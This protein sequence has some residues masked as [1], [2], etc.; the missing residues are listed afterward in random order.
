MARIQNIDK[1]RGVAC[2]LVVLYHCYALT[3]LLPF[4]IPVL[5]DGI[6]MGG[7]VG[8]T[9]FFLLSGYG[10]YFSINRLE[11]KNQLNY[12]TFLKARIKRI[13]PQYYFNIAIMLLF[14]SS[15]VYLAKEHFLTILSHLLFFHSW[16]FDW[17]GAINGVLWTMSVIFQFYLIAIPLYKL[18]KK[19]GNVWIV[20]V[21]S[22]VF[23]ILMKWL[24]LNYIWVED[25][26][27][28]GA[29]AYFIPGRQI[30]TSLDNFVCG[31]CVASINVRRKEITGITK[32]QRFGIGLNIIIFA[33]LCVCA[34]KYGISGRNIWCYSWYSLLAVNLALFMCCISCPSK[35]GL[36]SR[37]LLFISKH[38]YGIYLWHL[39][40]I[41]NVVNNSQ[42]I[43]KLI[44]KQNGIMLYIVLLILC[45]PIGIVID[46]FFDDKTVVKKA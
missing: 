21:I 19:I 1:F 24:M 9:M 32:I 43:R 28:Y 4:G 18:M 10:I 13:V 11:N 16:S 29:Y 45:V 33:V 30:V 8:V 27:I 20:A 5:R 25:E 15:V 17:H 34:V 2:L 36:I 7:T 31:M 6:K 39:P 3:G 46:H 40:V 14:T 38:E 23:T 42:G 44:D 22:V 12:S 26:T 37:F 35:D 41:S